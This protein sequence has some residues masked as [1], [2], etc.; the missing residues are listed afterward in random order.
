MLRLPVIVRHIITPD[1]PLAS[2]R[3]GPA[4]LSADADAEIY[5]AVRFP[6]HAPP[7]L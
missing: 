7:V 6:L 2:W 5:V 1:S 3:A 4:G